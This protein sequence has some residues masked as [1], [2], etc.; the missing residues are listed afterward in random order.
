[1]LV[2]HLS[3]PWFSLIYC[4]KKTIEVR[5]DKGHFHDLKP[6]DTIEFFN[7][8]LGFNMRRKF[9]IKV[10]SIEKFDTFELLLEKYISNAL[11][12]VKSIEFGCQILQQYYSKENELNKYKKLAINIERVSAVINEPRT[13]ATSC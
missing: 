8:E 5:L 4:G 7:D 1:M 6:Q 3:E 12:T 2:K 9:C 11:P 13:S 10:I